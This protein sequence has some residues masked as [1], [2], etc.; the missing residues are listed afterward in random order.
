MKLERA[1]QIYFFECAAL[2]GKQLTG[3]PRAPQSTAELYSHAFKAARVHV[4]Q[5]LREENPISL[6]AP[7]GYVPTCSVGCLSGV[8]SRTN[9][10]QA[11]IDTSNHGDVHH[12]YQVDELAKLAQ[13]ADSLLALAGITEEG[14][15]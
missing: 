12:A 10:S 5:E 8:L 14:V 11:T 3:D 15:K 6:S 1:K 7:A 13:L 4:E 2:V 9:V